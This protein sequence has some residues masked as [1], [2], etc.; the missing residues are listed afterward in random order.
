MKSSEATN[1][2]KSNES[3]KLPFVDLRHSDKF[4]VLDDSIVSERLRKLNDL[5]RDEVAKILLAELEKDDGVLITVTGANISPTLEHATI[6]I[7]VYPKNLSEQVLEKINKKIYA[8]QQMLNKCLAMRPV[9]KIRF[10]ID[11]TEERASKID[12]LFQNL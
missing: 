1:V 11:L 7:S 3:Y 8:I 2:S 12:K 5:L 6:K 9:P 4:V 10:E